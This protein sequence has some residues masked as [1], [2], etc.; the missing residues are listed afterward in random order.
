[1]RRP[2][3]LKLD[4][5]HPCPLPARAARGSWWQ[6]QDAPPETRRAPSGAYVASIPNHRPAHILRRLAQHRSALRLKASSL[7]NVSSML[8]RR[9]PRPMPLKFRLPHPGGMIENSPAF[10][11]LGLQSKRIKS[12]RDGRNLRVAHFVDRRI[13]PSL[14]DLFDSEA[15]PSVETLYVFSV[16]GT[17]QRGV[18]VNNPPA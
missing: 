15:T 14:R 5:P 6:C 13:Q 10:P 7:C 18:G 1:M 17:V 4:S 9:R 11:T 12:R 3:V 8:M 2:F 16:V